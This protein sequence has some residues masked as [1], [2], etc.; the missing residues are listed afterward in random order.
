MDPPTF[1]YRDLRPCQQI[2]NSLAIAVFESTVRSLHWLKITE[3]IEYN[4]VPFTYLQSFHNY[5]APITSS[6][7]SLLAALALHLARRLY[8]THHLLYEV[9]CMNTGN[10][11]LPARCKLCFQYA[12][13]RLWNKLPAFISQPRTNLSNS[14]HI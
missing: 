11:F 5:H 4:H 6:Q 9:L 2:Q 7:F 1:F 14:D 10:R 8:N 13:P 12:S 3:H